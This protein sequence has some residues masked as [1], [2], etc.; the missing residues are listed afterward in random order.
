VQFL[1]ATRQVVVSIAGET[2]WLWRAVDQNGFVLDVLGLHLKLNDPWSHE[3]GPVH[4]VRPWTTRSAAGG[5]AGDSDEARNARRRI[6]PKAIFYW[7]IAVSRK[8]SGAL[9]LST[10]GFTRTVYK[11]MVEFSGGVRASRL[12]ALARSI[13]LAR[14]IYGIGC[15]SRFSLNS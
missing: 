1:R 11:G 2:H 15:R 3:R 9:L 6:A 12:K 13:C 7:E 4:S 10:S 5:A 14:P 8:A